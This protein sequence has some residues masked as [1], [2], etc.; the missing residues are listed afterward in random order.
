METFQGPK[1][2]S[3]EQGFA[4]WCRENP[5]GFYVNYGSPDDI[6]LHRQ[7]CPH[8]DPRKCLTT[9]LKVCSTD[10][11]QLIQWAGRRGRLRSCRTC[12]P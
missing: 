6:V 12:S 8:L 4:N 11:Q 7:S 2:S 10:R 9:Y 1:G 3:Q 5:R